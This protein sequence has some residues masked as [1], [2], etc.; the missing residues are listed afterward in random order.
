MSVVMFSC[1]KIYDSA[2]KSLP[3][4]SAS[5]VYKYKITPDFARVLVFTCSGKDMDSVV[6]ALKA[7]TARMQYT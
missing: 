1:H 2:G 4:T 7:I 5:S 6:S 3:N